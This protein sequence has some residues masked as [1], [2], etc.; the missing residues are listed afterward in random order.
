MALARGR[1][2][3]G[4]RRQLRYLLRDP[5]SGA[6]GVVDPAEAE[7][8]L[9]RLRELGRGLDWAFITHHHAD[10]I[11]GL[12]SCRRR[13]AAGR[14]GRAPTPRA[15]RASTSRSARATSSAS[16]RSASS[17]WRRPA[18]PAAM[19]ATGSR[20]ARPCSAATP[21]SRSA[22]A[23]LFEGDARDH[24]ALAGQA[25]WRL[26]DA[27]R[28]FCGH[29]YTLSNAR[30]AL[31]IDPDNQALVPAG[32]GG[33]GDARRGASPPSRAPSAL[34]KA[35]NPFLRAGDRHIRRR[36]GLE[37]AH[38]RRGVRRDPPAEGCGLTAGLR[39]P[40][41]SSAAGRRR[42]GRRAP[43]AATTSP[44]PPVARTLPR[45]SSTT[46]SLGHDLV[47]E[48]GR[49]EHGQTL[50]PAQR[51]H[52]RRRS[53]GG[54]PCRDRPSARRAPEGCGRCS[55]ARPISTRRFMPAAEGAHLA[56]GPVAA[57]AAAPAPRRSRPA[58]RA[59]P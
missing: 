56:A 53:R 6:S 25:R 9:R 24:V 8:V 42:R 22:A 51:V 38:R 59:M 29:E 5:A 33:R 55:S 17:S 40:G 35:T 12:P 30:F 36:L 43:A 10:H 14:S 26:P 39:R 7:P 48:V 45:C 50:V 2:V 41:A 15:S 47:D 46:R 18:T 16:A 57:A 49:P 3:A 11:G 19:S 23:A 54:S 28:V 4:P 31:G 20:K 58:G 32:S 52:M 37:R 1:T 13:P 44:M 27:T 21:C 34:E